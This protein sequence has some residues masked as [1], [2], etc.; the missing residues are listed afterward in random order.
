MWRGYKFSV[1]ERDLLITEGG[2]WDKVGR[3]A[4]WSG[5]LPYVA[6]QNH[7]FKA[8]CILSEQN[9][10]W[11]EKYLNSPCARQYFASS[12]KQTTNL[13]SINKTQL[14]GTLVAIPPLP[15]QHRIVTKVDELLTLCDTLKIRLQQAQTTQVQLADTLVEQAVE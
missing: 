7:I 10:F 12:S 8:R 15:E 13:A 5:E 6:H 2:D 3:T 4:R 11:F 9:E 14:R 1:Q